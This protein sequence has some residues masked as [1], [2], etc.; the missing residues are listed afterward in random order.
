MD[1]SRKTVLITGASRGIGYALAQLLDAE[2][3]NLILVARTTDNLDFGPKHLKVNCDLS[4]EAGLHKLIAIVGKSQVDVLVNN[5]GVGIY[6]PMEGLTRADL[7]S[8]LQLNLVAPF[9]LTRQLMTNLR[10]SDLSLVLTIGSGAGVMPFKNRSV[11]CASK[12]GLRGLMLSL[13]EEYAHTKPHFC[14]ITLGSTITTFAGKSISDQE[15]ALKQG[16]AAFPVAWVAA[17]LVEII[18]DPD[19]QVEITLYPG[20][21]G[22]GVYTKP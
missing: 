7:E 17:K 15:T 16:K 8:S 9:E 12:F 13:A 3:A 10:Q 5:A 14:L 22:F 6:K 20:D 1:L 2:G 11:Y 19:W 21:Q 4:T 18:K